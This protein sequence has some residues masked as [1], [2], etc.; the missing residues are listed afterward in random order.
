MNR[1]HI[2]GAIPLPPAAKTRYQSKDGKNQEQK[3]KNFQHL[4]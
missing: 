1:I 4:L 2:E 3:K